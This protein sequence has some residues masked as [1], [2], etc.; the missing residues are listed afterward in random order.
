LNSS[1]RIFCCFF[2]DLVIRWWLSHYFRDYNELISQFYCIK[3]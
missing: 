3:I 1:G 2:V